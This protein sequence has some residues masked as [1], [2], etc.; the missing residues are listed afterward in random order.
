MHASLIKCGSSNIRSVYN[1]LNHSDYIT[2]VEVVSEFSNTP[3]S[4]LV[5]LPG[6]G[7]FK[8][9]STA[10]RSSC[11][12]NYL[13]DSR[14]KGKLIIGICL[15]AQ[16]MLNGSEEDDSLGDGLGWINGYVK[17]IN[18]EHRPITGWYNSHSFHESR[19]MVSFSGCYYHNHNYMMSPSSESVVAC[20]LQ[21][22][23]IPSILIQDNLIAL[24]FHPE[25]SQAQGNLLLRHIKNLVL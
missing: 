1:W 18:L 19:N 21:D 7:S 10:I 22:T 5:I 4:D 24:Q 2:S 9:L 25:K 13:E 8:Q 6:V 15:G 16:I 12:L 11:A 17:K 20:S 3:N 23:N 14:A